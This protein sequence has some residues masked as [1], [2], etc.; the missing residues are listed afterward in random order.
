MSNLENA[1]PSVVTIKAFSK[2]SYTHI[3]RCY[4]TAKIK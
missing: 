3:T 4:P 1:N 2:L